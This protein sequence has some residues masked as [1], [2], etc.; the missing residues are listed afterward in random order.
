M[1]TKIE[2]GECGGD[3]EIKWHVGESWPTGAQPYRCRD[4]G[5]RITSDDLSLDE[6]EWEQVDVVDGRLVLGYVTEEVA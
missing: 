6:G 4:C 2:C 5:H 1:F 3:Y